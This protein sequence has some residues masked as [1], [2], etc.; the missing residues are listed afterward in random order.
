MRV[1]FAYLVELFCQWAKACCFDEVR[2]FLVAHD[3]HMPAK[4]ING[5]IVWEAIAILIRERE[6]CM[7][8][9]H[10]KVAIRGIEECAN[11]PTEVTAIGFVASKVKEIRTF[12]DLAPHILYCL[13]IKARKEVVEVC[14]I[15]FHAQA[16][17]VWR[18]ALKLSSGAAD[19]LEPAVSPLLVDRETSDHLV[20]LFFF[21]LRALSA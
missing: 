8:C 15:P 13:H 12:S 1:T 11:Q 2:A 16:I 5:S 14:K 9:R 4:N 6:V 20:R 7:Q 18:L 10:F 3:A 17:V 19:C 21:A